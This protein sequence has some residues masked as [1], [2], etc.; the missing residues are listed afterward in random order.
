MRKVVFTFCLLELGEQDS[1]TS[2]FRTVLVLEGTVLHPTM[3][4]LL[5]AVVQ[6][7][8]GRNTVRCFSLSPEGNTPSLL[9]TL[10][11]TT[12][13]ITYNGL[14]YAWRCQQKTRNLI[15]ANSVYIPM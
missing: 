9:S 11:D 6:L 5:T 7:G 1:G 10:S 12:T 15:I 13:D 14:T 4:K 8:R 2:L 3:Y